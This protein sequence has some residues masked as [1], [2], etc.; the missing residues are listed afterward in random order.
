MLM[1][2]G[3]CWMCSLAALCLW[4]ACVVAVVSDKVKVM[5]NPYPQT[6]HDF[7]GFA[8]CLYAVE[9][10]SQCPSEHSAKV[11]EALE[12]GGVPWE[13]D[14]LRGYD[15][16]CW[17]PLAL[18]FPA[19]E[20]PVVQ[21]SLAKSKDS[22]LHVQMGKA[23]GQLRDEGYLLLCTGGITLGLMDM[24]FNDGQPSP[25]AAAFDSWVY[26]VLL[27]EE[28]KAQYDT[29]EEAWDGR[30][31][32]LMR[33]NLAIEGVHQAAKAC[34]PSGDHFL[35]L[36]VAAASGGPSKQVR[37]AA[38]AMRACQGCGRRRALA[39]ATGSLPLLP[40]P[41]SLLCERAGFSLSV[42]VQGSRILVPR[43]PFVV[44][45]SCEGG[46]VAGVNRHP[47]PCPHPRLSVCPSVC[48]SQ[49]SKSH[50]CSCL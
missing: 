47:P 49:I 32:R 17:S 48:L 45:L 18:L 31:E 50:S 40:L 23:L 24:A 29:A 21:V 3:L 42:W 30:N 7:F 10:A 1:Q 36:I 16:G 44:P 5:S 33:W 15:F 37:R 2:A 19:A 13:F 39:P 9:Y 27:Y 35:P 8:E 38:R 14:G 43:R 20:V 34:H 22:I 25:A 6:V 4:C 28:N 12:A 26:E 11:A 46:R 41:R